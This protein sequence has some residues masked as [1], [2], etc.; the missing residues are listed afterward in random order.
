MKGVPR[1]EVKCSRTSNKILKF[2]KQGKIGMKPYVHLPHTGSAVKW[3]SPNGR[4]QD[5]KADLCN[6]AHECGTF[7]PVIEGKTPVLPVM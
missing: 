2:A 3:A 6:S 7:V 5:G 4:M 1:T